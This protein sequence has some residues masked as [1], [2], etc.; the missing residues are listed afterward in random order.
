MAGYFCTSRVLDP[1]TLKLLSIESCS[2]LIPV[3]TPM[4]EN[5]PITTPSSVRKARSLFAFSAPQ[6]MEML[7]LMSIVR[8][9]TS[10]G[11]DL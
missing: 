5:T 1:S 11:P 9:H 10:V 4:K 8:I 2:T 7:S 6:A 3:I